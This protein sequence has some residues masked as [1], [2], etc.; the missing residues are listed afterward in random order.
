MERVIADPWPDGPRQA[1]AA[2]IPGTDRARLIADELTVLR[3]RRAGRQARA[4]EARVVPLRARVA[5]AIRPELADLAGTAR[6]GVGRGF[7]ES[8]RA[9]FAWL[10][11]HPELFERAPI[12]DVTVTE[13]GEDLPRLLTRPWLRRVRWLGL[14]QNALGDEAVA[15][16]AAADLPRLCALDL[17]A[18]RVGAAGLDALGRTSLPS[19]RFV[20]LG[21]IG[22]AHV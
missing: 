3:A 5:I 4:E 17:A 20:I 8:V 16:I 13:L 15:R 9:P 2:T 18:N 14:A 11:A 7:Y 22:R 1:F 19:L 21:E 12:L 10:D 6:F